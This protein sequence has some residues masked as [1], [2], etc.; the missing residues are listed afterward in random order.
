ML[1]QQI[2]ALHST[3][4]QASFLASASFHLSTVSLSSVSALS[5]HL[6]S[7]LDATLGSTESSKAIAAII[8]LIR[9]EFRNPATGVNGEVVGV[10]DLLVGSCGFALL[11][12]WGKRKTEQEISASSGEET[13]WDVVIL[14]DGT[15]A[16]VVESRSLGPAGPSTAPEGRMMTRPSSF[17]SISGEPEDFQVVTRPEPQRVVQASEFPSNRR[18]SWFEQDL[19]SHIMQQLPSDAHISI[20]SQTITTRTISVEVSSQSLPVVEPPPGVIVLREEY[21]NDDAEPPSAAINGGLPTISSPTHLPRYKVVYQAVANQFRNTSIG[22]RQ[23]DDAHPVSKELSETSAAVPGDDVLMLDGSGTRSCSSPEPEEPP[24]LPSNRP[25]DAESV[26]ANLD[27]NL[28]PE[29]TVALKTKR[30]STPDCHLD[31]AAN[32]KRQRKPLSPSSPVIDAMKPSSRLPFG[33]FTK[34]IKQGSTQK[35]EEHPQLRY[36]PGKKEAGRKSEGL[37]QRNVTTPS[38]PKAADAKQHRP[39]WRSSSKAQSPSHLPV[40]QKS[41]GPA[42]TKKLPKLPQPGDP[43]DSS[44]QDLGQVDHISRTSPRTNYYSIH[45]RRR[46]SVVSQTDTYSIH[47]IDTRPASPTQTRVELKTHSSFS[48]SKSD[49]DIS[50]SAT[51][52]ESSSLTRRHQRSKSFIPSIYAFATTNSR[53]S[54]V[55]SGQRSN[56]IYDDPSAISSLSRDGYLPGSFPRLHFVRNLTRFARFSS[57]SYGA[58]FLRLMGIASAEASSTELDVLHH[59]EHH[60]FSSHT[61]LPPSTI[62]LSSFVDPQGGSNAAGETGTNVPLVHYVSLDHDSQAVVL[63]CRGTL[64]FEDVLTDMTCDYDELV[65]RGKAYQVHKGMH[66]SARRLLQG[67]G[68]RVMATIRAALEEFSE[69]GLVMCGHS[70]GGG[71]AA[72]LAILLS[73]PDITLSSGASFVTASSP[74]NPTLS[75]PRTTHPHPFGPP[76]VF[77]PSH[78]PIHV[79]AYGPPASI[80]PSLRRATRGLITTIVNGADIV[81]SLS[82]GVLH[83]FQAVALAFKT[84]TSGVKGQFRKRVW[85]GLSSNLSARFA[86]DFGAFSPSGRGI[87]VDAVEEDHWAWASLKALRATMQNPKLLPPGE[88]F[89]VE[90]TPVLQRDAFTAPR[91]GGGG[92]AAAS[93]ATAYLGRP[94]TRVRLKFV[95]DVERRFG[96]IRFGAGMLGDHS[97]GRYEGGLGGLAK[98]VLL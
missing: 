36:A 87:D 23:L 27:K 62:L 92:A 76:P 83:D 77:L 44:S 67:G 14:S 28:R 97:P 51:N 29:G 58:N 4:T 17:M 91:G 63:T 89:V 20:D 56:S 98:G 49:K 39:P 41:F 59:H 86:P 37:Q 79:Y 53:T 43:S 19:R 45:Q 94:A 80:S 90:T 65:W 31:K 54:L 12:R 72:L 25:R 18:D 50:R 1:R 95:R 66:A 5:Q 52:D 7:A 33:R 68:G 64:G 71:V 85:E 88:V 84:D 13:V 26:P 47:S 24:T 15:K 6:L 81:P 69:Y 38:T 42:S 3:I 57:A 30:S 2:A 8:T 21:D 16:D 10:A 55:L 82:L 11:Q 75:S 70:L 48:R 9:R 74:Q 93:T 34:R 46:D 61:G 60:S 22:P 40:T 73:E 32:Q 96:E 78:R 35:A